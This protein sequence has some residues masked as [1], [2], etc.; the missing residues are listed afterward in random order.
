MDKKLS[1]DWKL[2]TLNDVSRKLSLNKLKIKQKEYLPN[3]LFPVIDQG[4]DLIGGYYNDAS[5]LVPDEPPYIIFGD[6]TKVKKYIPFKF[7]P[8]ADGVKVLKSKDNILPKFLYYLLFT[9]RIEDKGYARHFQLLEKE[10][11]L[12][13]DDLVTQQAIVS[14]IEELFSEL[15][16][17]IEDFKTAQLQLKTYRQSVLK[18]AFE[19]KLT[20]EDLKDSELPKSWV[21]KTLGEI[22]K[23]S[24]GRGIKIN[25]LKGGNYSV[26]G[27]NGLNGYHSEY[28]IEEPILIIGRVGVKCGVTHITNPKSWVSD[29]ALIVKPIISDFDIKFFKLRLEFENLN[30]LSVSTAQPVISGNSIYSVSLSLPKKEEQYLIVQEIESRLSVADKMEESIS[31]SLLQAEALRQSILKKAF[32]GELV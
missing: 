27:G 13:P 3:G 14:K 9:I 29:N 21:I 25:Q 24:S 10:S 11:F 28:F 15:D 5:L 30:K 8:G 2:K 26:Y 22:F 20:N 31:Q 19:G 32:S 7:I 18:W 4:Q 1:K 17:G 12:I 6:H 16:K 23:V